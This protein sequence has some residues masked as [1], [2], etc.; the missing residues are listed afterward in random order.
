MGSSGERMINAAALNF[1]GGSCASGVII[2]KLVDV[3]H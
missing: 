3:I 1:R 2:E